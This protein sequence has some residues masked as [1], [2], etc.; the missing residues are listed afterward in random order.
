MKLLKLTL[1]N[2]KGIR[3]FEISPNGK[4][5]TVYG[6]NGTGKT[7]LADAQHWLLFGSDSVGTKFYAQT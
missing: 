2:F 4:S 7:T 3:N 6:D 5:A 1:N